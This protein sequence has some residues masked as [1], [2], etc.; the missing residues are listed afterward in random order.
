M[1]KIYKIFLVLALVYLGS[2]CT[3]DF[4]DRDP[5]TS[6][7]DSKALSSYDKLKLATNGLYANFIKTSLYG[8]FMVLGPDV[9]SDNV[10]RSSVKSS[11]R[12][13]QEFNLTVGATESSPASLYGDLY[14]TV[15]AACNVINAI[16]G[17]K[18]DKQGASEAQINQLL[19]EA[20]FVKAWCHFDACRYFAYPYNFTDA[21]LAPGAN[22]AGGHPGVPLITKMEIQEV[23]RSTVK[24]VYESVIGDLKRA[25]TLMTVQKKACWASAEVAKAMLARVYLYKEDYENAAKM[26]TE[27]IGSGRYS[28]TAANNFVTYWTKGEQPETIFEIQINKSDDN[29]YGGNNNPGGVYL[30]YGDLVASRKLVD[31]YED[32]DVRLK[33]VELNGDGEYTVKKYPGRAD[34]GSIEINNAN[35]LRLAEMYLIRAEANFKGK[36][37]IGDTP[38]ND[39]NELR[40]HRGLSKISEVTNTIIEEERQKELAFEGHRLFDLGRNKQNNVRPECNATPLVTYPDKRYIFPIPLYEMNN[41]ENMEQTIGY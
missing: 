9:M 29:F 27:V 33:L 20:L 17:G 21:A 1:N 15:N 12:Y 26:A 5:H 16:E 19:G 23:G 38:L 18:F 41:N 4:L 14:Y 8:E 22:G 40:T 37:A 36:K 32:N 34:A 35:I 3:N 30:Y 24:E 11:G 2:A 28:L 25:A 7:S 10:I 6:I 13:I 31:L 39:I